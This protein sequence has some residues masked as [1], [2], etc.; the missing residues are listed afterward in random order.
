MKSTIF[1]K[2]GYNKYETTLQHGTCHAEVDAMLKLPKQRKNKK[3]IL[4]VFTTNKEANK[5]ITS[6]CCENCKK[7]IK[8]ISKK[9]NYTIQ[10]IYCFD[11]NNKLITLD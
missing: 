3:I 2:V 7:S 8:L 1:Y 5:L 11:K 9:K 10:K 6:E 4:C